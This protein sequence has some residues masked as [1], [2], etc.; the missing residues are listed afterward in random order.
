MYRE[1]LPKHYEAPLLVHQHL[2]WMARL[3]TGERSVVT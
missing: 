2:N 3:L 1:P